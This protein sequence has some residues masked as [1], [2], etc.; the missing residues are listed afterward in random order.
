MSAGLRTALAL[1]LLHWGAVLMA[2]TLDDIQQRGVLRHLGV[3]YAH[4]VTGAGDGLDVELIQGFAA[5]LGVEYRYVPTSWENALPDLLGVTLLPEGDAVR[6]GPPRP[7]R[8]DLLASGVTRL[9]WREQFALFSRPTFPSSVWLLARADSPLQPIRPT[10]VLQE[11]IALTRHRLQGGLSILTKSAT[12]LDARLYRLAEEDVVV[13]EAGERMGVNELAP[14]LLRRRAETTLLDVPD[15]LIA[16]EKWAGQIKVIG[17]ISAVQ[18]MGVLFRPEDRRLQ[19]RFNAY[20][21][22]QVRSG[23]YDRLI[24][25]YYANIRYHFPEFFARLA[26]DGG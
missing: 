14:A 9:P 10:G 12:C 6:P 8:G 2:D 1:F 23:A 4:F 7:S 21:A 19:Q 11:D 3:P 22:E 13:L 26:R 18:E 16:L 25:K 20:F 17:P 24:D 15:A 5:E